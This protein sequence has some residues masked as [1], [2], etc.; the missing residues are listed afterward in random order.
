MGDYS[1]IEIRGDNEDLK[2]SLDV[3][4]GMFKD[5]GSHVLSL[6]QQA[7][8][9]Y[10][11]DDAIAKI[12][13]GIADFEQSQ[14]HV[15]AL[16]RAMRSAGEAAGFTMKQMGEMNDQ[17]KKV[18]KYT[19]D[20]ITDAQ[21]AL[22]KF[23]NVRL[24]VF[25][26]AL[27]G[28]SDL[29]EYLGSDLTTATKLLGAALNDPR[30]GLEDLE[31]AGV[32]FS[33]SQKDT[34]EAMLR[35]GDVAGAQRLILKQLAADMGGEGAK[36]ADT[37]GQRMQRWAEASDKVWQTIGGALVPWLNK[38]VDVTDKVQLVISKLV[39]EWLSSFGGGGE[40]SISVEETAKVV[41]EWLM[42]AADVGV[43]AFT[44][45]QSAIETW[46]TTAEGVWLTI[47]SVTLS[48]LADMANKAADTI[49]KLI[50]MWPE[51]QKAA[52]DMW[53]KMVELAGWA[54]EQTKKYWDDFVE[55]TKGVFNNLLANAKAFASALW[56]RLKGGD[57]KFFWNDFKNAGAHVLDEMPGL[58]GDKGRQTIQDKL[59]QFTDD[60][61]DDADKAARDADKAFQP[62][63]KAFDDNLNKNRKKF[64]DFKDKVQGILDSDDYMNI[65]G[66]DS[67]KKFKLSEKDKAEGRERSEQMGAFEDFASMHN[68]IQSAAVKPP[69]VKELE[70]QTKL[71][72]KELDIQKAM[73][74]IWRKRGSGWKNASNPPVPGFS[75]TGEGYTD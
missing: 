23:K 67:G 35:M 59:R 15:R 17:L 37:F 66:K 42:K 6:F 44:V 69:D 34:I 72:E 73:Y 56:D 19:T 51:V 10:S 57:A 63:D 36:A 14:E 18:S 24:D 8:G 26:D 28:A 16:D 3:A 29:A 48:V 52:A 40:L 5:F 20:A 62:F 70:K 32:D 4:E 41:G 61:L 30:K 21:A 74:D 38:L 46:R 2:S 54:W 22:S 13:K 11:F 9:I 45:L 64:A 1:T 31:E 75:I 49:D 65:E 68:R 7:T 50:E 55:Y 27:K 47:K 43:Q 60:T 33:R 71:M 58:V 25:Q 39:E 53:K 12:K